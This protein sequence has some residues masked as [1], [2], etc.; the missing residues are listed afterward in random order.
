M[1]V[2]ANPLLSNEKL[3]GNF[4]DVGAIKK[5]IEK[6]VGIHNSFRIQLAEI[7]TAKDEDAKETYRSISNSYL[8][9]FNSKE[10][11]EVSDGVVGIIGE[12]FS[13]IISHIQETRP[14]NE[15]EKATLEEFMFL[16]ILIGSVQQ[17]YQ[18]TKKIGEMLAAQEESQVSII[19]NIRN[20]ILSSL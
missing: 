19:C 6:F 3:L 20:H 17:K 7:V 8:V 9:T 16:P 4:P 5:L 2:S 18:F 11:I 13:K 1:S 15:T 12:G 14:P 10:Y